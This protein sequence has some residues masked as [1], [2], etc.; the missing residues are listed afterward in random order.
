MSTLHVIKMRRIGPLF[1]PIAHRLLFSLA[2]SCV[3]GGGAPLVEVPVIID[4]FM[5]FQ[6]LQVRLPFSFIA[7]AQGYCSHL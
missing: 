5:Q 1:F 4:V 7:P 3:A 2:V 6:R